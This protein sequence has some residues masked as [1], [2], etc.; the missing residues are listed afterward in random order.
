MTKY[1]HDS[2]IPFRDSPHNK[3]E[4]IAEMFDGIAFRYDFLNRFLSGGIDR[5]WRRKAISELLPL[6]PRFILD[7]ATG[8]GD[9]PILM[10]KYLSPEKITGIDISEGML[11]IGKL[12]TQKLQLGKLIVLEIG[13]AEAL[14]YPDNGF[15][16][17]TVAF[18]V[19]NFADL[20]KGLTEM[21]RTLRPGGKLVV[22]EFSK[23]KLRG[24]KGLYRFYMRRVATGIGRLISKSPE[25]Y[26]YL[27]ESVHSFP[28]GD[29]FLSI[30]SH[31]GFRENQAKPL[32]LGIC[33]LYTGVK[34][35]KKTL[36][37]WKQVC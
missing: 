30:L 29:D 26:A 11:Q 25:A 31:A 4:Q 1:L 18:G 9:M 22:L 35:G 23:P 32:S 24:F 8:T 13:D 5:Y 36:E 19:R 17:I 6:Q 20:E 12:K 27:E 15:D 10:S 37:T 28:E 14:S 2:V 34:P 16:A 7:V 33:T 3:K 21:F